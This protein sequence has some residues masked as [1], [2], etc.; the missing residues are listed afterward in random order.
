MQKILEYP[1]LSQ[2]LVFL[3]LQVFD[4]LNFA[5]EFLPKKKLYPYQIFNFLKKRITYKN[6]V[7]GIEQLQ[8]M[9]TLFSLNN[10]HK[11]IGFGDCDCFTITAL[12]SLYVKNYKDLKV[13][14]AGRNKVNPCHIYVKVDGSNFDLTEKKFN[15]AR[16]YPY[17]QE[18][19]FTL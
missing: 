8:T 7:D 12:A 13:I 10:V 6:D 16:Y 15:K 3:K 9:Q 2:T 5:E 14:L 1:S 19:T 11:N 17:L 18:L 4:S